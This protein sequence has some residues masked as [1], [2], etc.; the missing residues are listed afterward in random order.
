VTGPA[1]AEVEVAGDRISITRRV[2]VT[3]PLGAGPEITVRKRVRNV[4]RD[5]VHRLSRATL[6]YTW[7]GPGWMP[8]VEL[9][10]R[11]AIGTGWSRYENPITASSLNGYR[12]VVDALHADYAPRTRIT[13]T[14]D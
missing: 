7:T 1:V 14:E 4:P 9:M 10:G 13:L 8:L 11:E 12:A 3:W 5:V 2:T 6:T